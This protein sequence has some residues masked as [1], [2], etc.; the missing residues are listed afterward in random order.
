MSMPPAELPTA[1][2]SHVQSPQDI[3]KAYEL[4]PNSFKLRAFFAFCGI[5]S[6]VP[7]Q[8]K[9]FMMG[10]LTDMASRAIDSELNAPVIRTLPQNSV[11][12]L[13]ETFTL[14]GV[15]RGRKDQ[16]VWYA[17]IFSQ[18]TE[19]E[20]W[21]IFA[22]GTQAHTQAWIQ[23]LQELVVAKKEPETFYQYASRKFPDA[24]GRLNKDHLDLDTRHTM[25]TVQQMLSSMQ[26]PQPGTTPQQPGGGSYEP[27]DPI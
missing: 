24:V 18:Y 15:L 13:V 2:P 17:G 26:Q 19:V 20:V 25:D 9:N 11:E 6:V 12:L 7:E 5:H 22:W 21:R 10:I 23:T 27:G 1:Q 4:I 8:S 14:M 16:E 3:L